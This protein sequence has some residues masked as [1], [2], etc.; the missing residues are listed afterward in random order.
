[1]D[2]TKIDDDAAAVAFLLQFIVIQEFIV[3]KKQQTIKSPN[4][5]N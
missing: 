5:T 1:M 3:R 4:Y 2:D